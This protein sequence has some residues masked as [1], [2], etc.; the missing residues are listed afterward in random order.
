MNSSMTASIPRNQGL[1]VETLPACD[2]VDRANSNDAGS[3]AGDVK[4]LV[5][6]DGRERQRPS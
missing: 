2:G 3:D 5:L 4:W 1:A 6:A